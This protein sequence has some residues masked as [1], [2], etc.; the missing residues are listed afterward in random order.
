[1]FSKRLL[2]A[3]CALQASLCAASA[4]ASADI[5]AP[6]GGEIKVINDGYIEVVNSPGMIKIFLYDKKL[7]LAEE[8]RDYSVVAEIQRPYS[9]DHEAL[10]LKN[11]SG[12]FVGSVKEPA[13]QF[14]DIGIANRKNGSADRVSFDFATMTATT[15]N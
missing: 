10:E 6:N 8:L 5:K 15:N 13:I 9:K 2:V 12:G 1:M 3:F 7:K 4:H 14:L 11:A